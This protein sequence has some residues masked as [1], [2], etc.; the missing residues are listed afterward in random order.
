MESGDKHEVNELENDTILAWQYCTKL[1]KFIFL[2]KKWHILKYI[3]M[4]GK[5]ALNFFQ[6]NE[7]IFQTG[8]KDLNIYNL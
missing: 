2:Y 7:I 4:L 3:S 1:E 5:Q 6:H 8:L